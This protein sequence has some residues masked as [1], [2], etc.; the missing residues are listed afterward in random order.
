MDEQENGDETPRNEVN[1]KVGFGGFRKKE[2]FKFQPVQSDSDDEFS[3]LPVYYPGISGCRSVE[4]YQC[5]NRIEEG[6]FGVVYRAKE[7]RTG[8]LID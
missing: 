6:T 4:E 7:K 5:I 1:T 8:W 3:H 2:F